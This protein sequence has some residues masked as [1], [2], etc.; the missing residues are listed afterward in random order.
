M[1]A[2]AAV[3]TLPFVVA[4]IALPILTKGTLIPWHP[5]TVDLDVYQFFARE[6]LR[7]GDILTAR[8]PRLGLPF[9]YPPFAALLFVPLAPLPQTLAQAGW[10]LLNVVAL[11]LVIRRLGLHGWK[12]SLVTA[13]C[14]VFVEPVRATFTFGQ[15]NLVLLALVFLDLTRRHA[16]RLQGVATGIAAAI[17]LTPGLF[18]IYLLFARQ[19]RAALTAVVSAVAVTAVTALVL[20]RETFGYVR[21]LLAGE[22]WPGATYYVTNQSVLGSTTRLLGEGGAA[23]VVGIVLA[24]VVGLT[25]AYAA[26]RW[27]RRGQ[28]VL[29]VTLC[30]LGSLLASPISWSH[31]WVW[32]VPLAAT[33]FSSELTRVMRW[34][35]AVFVVWTALAPFTW[36][37]PRGSQIELRYEPWQLA[38]SCLGTFLAVA[39]VVAALVA[40]LQPAEQLEREGRLR[41][42]A[43]R[44]P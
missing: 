42:R 9:T 5:I 31:H 19:W 32:V 38:V 26:A 3:V 36:A 30:G 21:M 2:A 22:I 44:H 13:V 41:Q 20:Q 43:N 35:G 12:L 23:P 7:G 10:I 39:F 1:F 16:H 18:V 14:I 27:H 37:L 8:E 17:K 6:L 15:V 40:A 4:L 29:A 28:L 25:A 24:V 11:V 34:N 33:L